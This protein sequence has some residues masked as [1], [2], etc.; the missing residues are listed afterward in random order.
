MVRNEHGEPLKVVAAGSLVDHGSG[1][2]VDVY[3]LL[4]G[5]WIA[6]GQ[7]LETAVIIKDA[8]MKTDIVS[9]LQRL[10]FPY[11]WAVHPACPLATRSS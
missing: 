11:P 5:D 8:A 10:L 3:N 6:T 2:E 7:L 4:T 1:Y 9:L